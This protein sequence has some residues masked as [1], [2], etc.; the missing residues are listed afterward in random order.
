MQGRQ[1]DPESLAQQVEPLRQ[2]NAS[3]PPV[4]SWHPEFSG[5]I[6]IRI[7]RDG[8]WYFKGAPIER[9][10][11]VTLFST[12][13][14]KDDDA[15]YYLVTPVEK[16]RIRVDDVPFVAHSLSAEGQGKDQRLSF[17]TNAG[18]TIVLGVDHPLEV[19]THV[20]TAE[21][22]PYIRVRR[23]LYALIERSTFYHLVELAVSREGSKGNE[24]GVWSEGNFYPIGTL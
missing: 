16:W 23:N 7:A 10:S 22:S 8:Q 2:K 3:L 5:D 18:D 11:F 19:K 14:R 6:D 24:L 17:V 13:L 9:Q 12:I 1:R 4:E 21:P 15:D 20:E